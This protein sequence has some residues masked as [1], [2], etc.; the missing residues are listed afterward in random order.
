M[1]VFKF[2]GIMLCAAFGEKIQNK[3]SN[4][5][6]KTHLIKY[7]KLLQFNKK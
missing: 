1:I 4:K 6:L 5:P 2:V 7:S 3:E